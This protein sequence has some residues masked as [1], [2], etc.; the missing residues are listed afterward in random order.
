L[1]NSSISAI[2]L[3][4]KIALAV[5][6]S[7]ANLL[8]DRRLLFILRFSIPSGCVPHCYFWIVLPRFGYIWGHQV[9]VEY[10]TR[11]DSWCIGGA[12]DPGTSTLLFEKDMA[13]RG[14][15]WGSIFQVHNF[16]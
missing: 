2:K 1:G 13:F 10:F 12:W 5:E 4:I 7:A 15:W 6:E 14:V 3:A 16:A 9:H 11:D 8:E